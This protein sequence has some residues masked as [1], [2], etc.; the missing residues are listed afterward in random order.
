ML[1]RPEHRRSPRSW[2][3]W[4]PACGRRRPPTRRCWCRSIRRGASSSGCARPPT[5]WPPML[6]VGAAGDAARTTQVG[7]ALGRGAGG[8]RRRL[9]LR[10]R[11]RRPHQPG[12]PG[13]RQPRLRD[14]AGGGGGAGAGV[15]ARAARGGRARLRQALPRARR[16]AGPTRTSICR[17]WRT[18]LERLRRI[19]L[20]PFAAAA[21]GRDGGVHDRARALPGARSRSAPRRCRAG[22]RPS[23]CAASWASAACWSPT[24]WG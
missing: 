11:A 15:L 7:R 6:A 12:Q 10:A 13:D 20:A 5:V 21:R 8:G 17:W 14:D 18:T 24:I 16:H 19:E 2:R 3:R 23:S 1:F 9:E 22:S 4:W